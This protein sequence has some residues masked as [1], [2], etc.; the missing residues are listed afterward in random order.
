MTHYYSEKQD[1]KLNLKKIT[2][3]AF[4]KSIELFSGKGVFSKDKLDTGSKLL[5][6]NIYPIPKCKLTFSYIF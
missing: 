5:I 6:E 1:S 4:N 2:V 3:R